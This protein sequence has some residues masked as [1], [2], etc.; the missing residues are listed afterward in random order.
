MTACPNCKSFRIGSFRL[1]SD[2]GDGGDWWAANPED[3]GYTPKDLKSFAN[4]E[5]P[6]IE[7]NVCCECGTCF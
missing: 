3:A 7:C 2:W 6:D 1:D 5:R 4:N